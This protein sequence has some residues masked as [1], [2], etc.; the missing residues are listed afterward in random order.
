MRANYA[1]A[2]FSSVAGMLVVPAPAP[3]TSD[4]NGPR[5]IAVYETLV[6]HALSIGDA[7]LREMEVTF[8]REKVRLFREGTHMRGYDTV[9]DSAVSNALAALEE[10]RNAKL[11][12]FRASQT[13]EGGILFEIRGQRCSALMEFFPDGEIAVVER[14]HGAKES[15]SV[16]FT[17]QNLRSQIAALNDAS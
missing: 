13:T 4:T 5:M 14:E 7:F 11:I 3:A 15:K 16:G 8:L 9:A 6:D 10:L 17:F 1:K 12:P 2:I